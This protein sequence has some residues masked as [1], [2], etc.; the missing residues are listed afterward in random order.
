MMRWGYGSSL[1]H[2]RLQQVLA[3]AA[4]GTA[5][6]LPVVLVSVGGGVAAHELAGL[7]NAGYQIVVSAAGA[8]GIVDSHNLTDRIRAIASVAAASPTLS[9]TVDVFP[10]G[11]SPTAV[12]AEGVIPD[13]FPATLP[14]EER[15]LFPSVLRLGDPTD[16]VHFD[17]GTYAGPA[18]NDVMISTALAAAHGIANGTT[19]L[20]GGSDNRSQA[21]AYIVTGSFG[22]ASSL[23]GP[24]E[25]SAVL[26]PLSNL[27]V[28][29]GLATGP[30]A[31]QHDASDTIEVSVTGG[32]SV[33]PAALAQVRAQIQSL[34]PFYAVTSL[35]Q[36]AQQLES[37]SGV[38]TGFY[39]ALSSVGLT[40][41]LLFLALVLVRRVESD[42]RSIGIRRALGL[43]AG[44][45]AREIVL[46]G[47]RLALLGAAVGVIGGYVLVEALAAWGSSGVR[48]AA[49]WARFDPVTIGAIVVGIV[50]LS[51]LASGVATRVALRIEITEALR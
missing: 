45:I 25:G 32:S 42:R 2:L 11:G 50:A 13:Q 28:L 30:D 18:S 5:V 22:A 21:V 15:D 6:A 16:A 10:S 38:L 41:G 17:N 39:L 47:I 4:V 8:H 23:L 44:S 27:Q 40:V 19:L 46:D 49:Q 33:D 26:L 14:P 7:E 12:P 51:L 29:G 9:L 1:R 48:L 36:E 35:G 37:A 20:I 31:F 34:V 43:P 3:I 24:V